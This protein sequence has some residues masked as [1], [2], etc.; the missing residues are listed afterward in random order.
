[1]KMKYS[2]LLKNDLLSQ[3]LF[4]VSFESDYKNVRPLDVIFESV[5][6][7]FDHLICLLVVSIAKTRCVNKSERST[8]IAQIG[9][10]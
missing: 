2:V 8:R 10:F 4:F 9:S 3:I 5:N 1:M 7:I 6:N